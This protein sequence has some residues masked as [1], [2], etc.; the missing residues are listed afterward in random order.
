MIAVLA[1]CLT[2]LPQVIFTKCHE[3]VIEKR[4][5]SVNGAA[6]LLCKTTQ[7]I[8][9]LQDRNFQTWI[10]LSYL[11]LKN[12]VII[13]IIPLLKYHISS[14]RTTCALS[15]DKVDSQ[16]SSKEWISGSS[17]RASGYG[18][19]IGDFSYAFCSSNS[20]ARAA[21]QGRAAIFCRLASFPISMQ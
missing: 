10:L 8:N 17:D 6:Q 1:A 7:I 13:V 15:F 16:K 9:N 3:N 11:S 21:S 5:S 19:K 14:G 4:E 12:G 20:S 2:N 18:A